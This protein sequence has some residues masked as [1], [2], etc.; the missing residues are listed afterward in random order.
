MSYLDSITLQARLGIASPISPHFLSFDRRSPPPPSSSPLS[1][2]FVPSLA[3][4]QCKIKDGSTCTQ[5]LRNLVIEIVNIDR[6]AKICLVYI[7]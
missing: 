7:K 1:T 3:P 4:P 5:K 2:N 6:F